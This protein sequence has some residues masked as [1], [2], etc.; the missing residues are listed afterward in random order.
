MSVHH[1]DHKMV[2]YPAFLF[3]RIHCKKSLFFYF[4][5]FE[6]WECEKLI[7]CNQ[8]DEGQVTV[9]KSVSSSCFLQKHRG[10]SVVWYGVLQKLQSFCKFLYRKKKCIAFVAITKHFHVILTNTLPLEFVDWCFFAKH[11]LPW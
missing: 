1:C 11:F 5:K 9:A 7:Y 2:L 10:L 3:F 8:R 6:A 4:F